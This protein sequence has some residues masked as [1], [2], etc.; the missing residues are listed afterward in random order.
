MGF[1]FPPD[2]TSELGFF[3]FSEAQLGTRL[4]TSESVTEGHPDKIADQISDALLDAFLI[5]DPRSRVACETLVTTGIVMVSG[6]VT[7]ESFVD[8]PEVVRGT[9]L[10]IGYSRSE[11]G[12]DGHTCGV[13]TT[14]DQQSPEISQGVDTGGAG[15]QG[16][17]FGY[18]SD[19]TE[20][21][22]PAPVYFAHRLTQRLARVRKE[23]QLPWLRP[24][25]KA[26]VTMEYRDGRPAGIH[27]VVMSAQHDP[28]IAQATIREELLDHVI[29]PALPT[30]L[31]DRSRCIF[32]V[33]PTGRFVIGGPHGDAGLTGRK[34]IVDTYGGMGRHGGGAFSGKDATKV[35]RSGAY[36][37][38]W[39]AKN[40]VAARLARR[41]EIQL[42]YAIGV[43]DPVSVDV[44]TFGTGRL[45]DEEIARAVEEVFDFRPGS[46]IESLRLRDPIFKPT[47]VYG[48]FGRESRE[49]SRDGGLEVRI[50]PW[51][52]LNRV[53]E[54]RTAAKV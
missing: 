33:N 5:Q 37:A 47:A 39:A 50:F 3:F 26:Q 36:A 4:F 9:L 48:H 27:T 16:M 54:L 22:M 2:A 49:V 8:I 20:E 52:A 30:E 24:D 53:E 51:E 32:H 44:E 28:E 10:S 7:T 34:I 12:M 1:A 40:V 18:A 38:R 31:F 23:G 29:T 43:P 11:F 45:A 46:I 35:D 25:G 41:C 6:E 17:M 19:E 15:D 14:L 13:L 21:L 42:A